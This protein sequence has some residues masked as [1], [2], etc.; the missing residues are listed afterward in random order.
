M[1]VLALTSSSSF[2]SIALSDGQK[3][4]ERTHSVPRGH[5]EF[6]NSALAEI[7]TESQFTFSQ[8]D[9]IA[10]DQGPGSFTGIRV[11]VNIA[12]S[13]CY[14]LQKPC[15]VTQST[16]LLCTEKKSI[17]VGINAFKNLIFCAVFESGLR[18]QPTR[19][20]SIPEIEKLAV[21]YPATLTFVG[22]AWA[23]YQNQWSSEFKEKIQRDPHLSDFP[24]ASELAARAHLSSTNDWIQD[25]NLIAPLYLRESAAEENLRK[26]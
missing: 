24:R 20:L 11:A 12:R 5:T 18:T 3:K 17:L 9:L 14:S 19:V 6:M 16:D 8:I 23:A 15:W 1:K 13:L 2:A 4:F 21:S 22:D 7:M 10:L 25:W 26:P